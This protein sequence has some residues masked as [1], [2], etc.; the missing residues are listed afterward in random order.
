M[1]W[2]NPQI[3]RP[4]DETRSTVY[5]GLYCSRP[6]VLPGDRE[7]TKGWVCGVAEKGSDWLGFLAGPHT[8]ECGRVHG[9]VVQQ[10]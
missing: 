1:G 2:E 4:L 5:D 10:G 6:M 3:P 8:I 9:S 7:G